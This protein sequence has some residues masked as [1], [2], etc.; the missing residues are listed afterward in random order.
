MTVGLET[1]FPWPEGSSIVWRL[2]DISGD[3]DATDI[4]EMTP[5]ATGLTTVTDIAF[6]NQGRL[7]AVEFRGLLTGED[8]ATGRV[9]RWGDGDWTVIA[10]GLTTPT[11][12]T[13]GWDDT[14]YVTQEY[15]GQIVS[16]RAR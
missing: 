10:G 14:I 9:M 15:V 13:V 7:L 1:G 5:Y 4:G 6:D 11:G 12:I 3:G 8:D 2:E 16:I